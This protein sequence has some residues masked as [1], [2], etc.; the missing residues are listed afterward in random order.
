MEGALKIDSNKGDVSARLMN[1]VIRQSCVKLIFVLPLGVG[2]HISY[3]E[4]DQSV[5]YFY[6]EIFVH[7]TS[8]LCLQIFILQLLATLRARRGATPILAS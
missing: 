8:V 7:L 6:I 5:R 3:L 1:F 2:H 4:T